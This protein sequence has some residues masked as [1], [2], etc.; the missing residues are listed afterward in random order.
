MLLSHP[1][2]A[3][4][5]G[6]TLTGR[7]ADA[8]LDAR[9]AGWPWTPNMVGPSLHLRAHVALDRSVGLLTHS[10][11]PVV[12]QSQHCLPYKLLMRRRTR[13]SVQ[14]SSVPGLEQAVTQASRAL[15]CEAL[16]PV[17]SRKTPLRTA[18]R[19]SCISVTAVTTF[20]SIVIIFLFPI[21]DPGST[22][23]RGRYSGPPSPVPSVTCPGCELS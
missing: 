1:N 6:L 22:A 7:W 11:L 9:V 5:A 21:K 8:F 4:K 18:R 23:L 19:G 10:F 15:G 14:K 2:D 16:P 20:A 12:R 3:K 13:S 17:R